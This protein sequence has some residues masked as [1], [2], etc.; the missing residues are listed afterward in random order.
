MIYVVGHGT[1]CYFCLILFCYYSNSSLSHFAIHLHLSHALFVFFFMYVSTWNM[2][3]NVSA[4]WKGRFTVRLLHASLLYFMLF[5]CIFPSQSWMLHICQKHT[6]QI[7]LHKLLL[8]VCI[9]FFSLSS[10]N[11]CQRCVWHCMQPYFMRPFVCVYVSV[12]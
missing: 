9:E 6:F 2:Y 8:Q 11:L 7:T 5:R 1:L 4:S 12:L 3:V 10:L